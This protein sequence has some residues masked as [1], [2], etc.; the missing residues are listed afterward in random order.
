MWSFIYYSPLRESCK[1]LS[2]LPWLNWSS[3]KT[4]NLCTVNGLI[5][6]T[7]VTKY[8]CWD[9]SLTQ[10]SVSFVS[11]L[12]SQDNWTIWDQQLCRHWDSQS[13]FLLRTHQSYKPRCSTKYTTA[14]TSTPEA[15]SKKL[16]PAGLGTRYVCCCTSKQLCT[17]TGWVL[18]GQYPRGAKQIRQTQADMTPQEPLSQHFLNP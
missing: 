17:W 7:Q 10:H 16:A 11:P 13:G 18:H 1:I 3:I 15:E 6:L 5:P 12:V 14:A 8:A 2:L 9:R 4:Y